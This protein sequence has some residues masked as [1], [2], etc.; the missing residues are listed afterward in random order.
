MQVG[1]LIALCLE[2]RRRK[3]EK[4]GA[5]A[6][7]RWISYASRMRGSGVRSIVQEGS[8]ARVRTF[9]ELQPSS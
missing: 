9:K 1:Y 6:H 4:R 7:C 3:Q 2:T 8:G 5:Q